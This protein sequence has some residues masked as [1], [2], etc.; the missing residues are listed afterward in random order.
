MTSRLTSRAVVS[1]AVVALT[2][3]SS[4]SGSD[5]QPVDDGE[6]SLE[7]ALP[8]GAEWVEGTPKPLSGYNVGA[9]Y[10]DFETNVEQALI[11]GD[12]AFLTVMGIEKN[13]SNP[14]LADFY[15]Q[16]ISL[17]TSDDHDPAGSEYNL[18]DPPPGAGIVDASNDR[19]AMSFTE[20]VILLPVPSLDDE[21]ERALS[22]LRVTYATDDPGDPPQWI[23]EDVVRVEVIQNFG[24][25][26]R[27]P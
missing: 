16:I 10:A 24:R 3:C 26:L 17:A 23:I 9:V 8:A 1:I 5:A 18:T 27:K 6:E 11:T 13:S 25:E 4:D 22:E 21:I 15:E 2:A 20:E 19:V 14:N 7:L 12:G